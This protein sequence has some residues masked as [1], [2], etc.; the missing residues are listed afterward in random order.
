MFKSIAGITL[1][2]A[3]L[4][5]AVEVPSLGA[6]DDYDEMNLNFRFLQN[7]ASTT[8]TT[9]ST[10]A[11]PPTAN[12]AAPIP[13][14]SNPL[15][16]GMQMVRMLLKQ[17]LTVDSFMGNVNTG[18]DIENELLISSALN[19]DWLGDPACNATDRPQMKPA[20]MM[21]VAIANSIGYHCAN[22]LS[23][24]YMTAVPVD[25]RLAYT[26]KKRC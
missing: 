18:S 5:Q 13:H 2:F 4:A 26:K 1:G 25:R 17:E 24:D 20:K 6:S 19:W 16:S 3:S 11:S 22:V 12:P 8:S 23:F 21:D 15:E 7:N 9:S 14:S 10:T